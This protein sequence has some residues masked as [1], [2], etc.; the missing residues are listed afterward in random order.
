MVL[1][2]KIREVYVMLVDDVLII[3]S[4]YKKRR[5]PF[6]VIYLEGLTMNKVHD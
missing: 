1:Q 6:K 4:S 3:A 2:G 5:T